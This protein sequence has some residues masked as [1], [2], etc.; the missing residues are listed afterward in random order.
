MEDKQ[1]EPEQEQEQEQIGKPPEILENPE[2]RKKSEISENPETIEKTKIETIK[3][4]NLIENTFSWVKR[5]LRSPPFSSEALK[6]WYDHYTYG[7]CGEN[8][9]MRFTMVLDGV[10]PAFPNQ[11]SSFWTK[12]IPIV[13]GVVENCPYPF[14]N[15]LTVR[16]LK[17]YEGG[18]E[19]VCKDQYA[20]DQYMWQE[21]IF[22]DLEVGQNP[23]RVEIRVDNHERIGSVSL[24]TF[25]AQR[26]C[27]L[28]VMMG[29]LKACVGL[30]KVVEI[31]NMPGWDD[32][33]WKTH[34][35]FNLF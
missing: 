24:I 16:Y 22:P 30:A 7:L 5:G 10:D 17:R 9:A 15:K 21:W 13:Q 33:I 6:S 26:N 27:P 2:K 8:S 31:E 23:E 19:F 14:G 18:F 3:K 11:E 1:K 32:P 25:A 4:A 12:W 28:V 20:L 34:S 35:L 29:F